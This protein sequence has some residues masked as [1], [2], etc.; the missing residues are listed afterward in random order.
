[1]VRPRDAAGPYEWRPCPECTSEQAITTD[2]PDLTDE[3]ISEPP[4]AF[5]D[6]EAPTGKFP[7]AINDRP[8]PV[9]EPELPREAIPPRYELELS[10]LTPLP[11]PRGM[12]PKT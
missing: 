11:I 10:R 4:P 1:M 2:P 3:A 7:Q 6:D 12:K 5:P 9:V 8:T